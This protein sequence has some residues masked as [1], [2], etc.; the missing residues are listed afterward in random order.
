VCA[1]RSE[2]REAAALQI[3]DVVFFER[4]VKVER[5]V[6][7]AGVGKVEIRLPKYGS[8]RVVPIPDQLVRILAAHVALMCGSSRVRV[9]LPRTRTRS[10]TG[11]ARHWARRGSKASACP[12]SPFVL[13]A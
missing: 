4:Q 2:T 8:E 6:Q 12:M 13:W 5:Q 7:R 10:G 9:T 3:G 1:R 11:G